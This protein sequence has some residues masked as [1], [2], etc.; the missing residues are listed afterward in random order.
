[1]KSWFQ[2][3]SNRPDPTGMEFL[4]LRIGNVEKLFEKINTISKEKGITWQLQ[5]AESFNGYH[6]S[7]NFVDFDGVVLNVAISDDE[8]QEFR[9]NFWEKYVWKTENKPQV[10]ALVIPNSNTLGS[11]T[12]A[13]V[14]ETLSLIRLTDRPIEI[15]EMNENTALEVT[16]WIIKMSI[17][18]HRK[19]RIEPET[20]K[21]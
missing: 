7:A 4:Y 11:L 9:K 10:T 19:L 13:Q 15:F 12:K 18:V 16:N 1:M 21:E 8:I 6:F 17:Y 2:F 5:E 14:I 3:A 20:T